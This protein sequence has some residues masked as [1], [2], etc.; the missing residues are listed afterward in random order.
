MDGF[1]IN[2]KQDLFDIL[3]S[4]QTAIENAIKNRSEAYIK[5]AKKKKDG[6]REIY[7]IKQS[8][9]IYMMQKCLKVNFLNNYLF[10]ECVFGFI[11]NRSYYDFLKPHCSDKERYF[12]RLDISHFLTVSKS[13]ILEKLLTI[14]YRKMMISHWKTKIGLLK[15]SVT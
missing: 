7:S 15:L 9:P 11:K 6:Y 13:Q 2:N 12:L 5:Y 8:H 4:D 14:I 10:P 3:Q 1:K